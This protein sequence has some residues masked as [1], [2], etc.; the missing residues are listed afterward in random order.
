MR[1]AGSEASLAAE[2]CEQLTASELRQLC[3]SRGFPVAGLSRDDLARGAA[4]RFLEPFGVREVMAALP[5]LWLKALHLVAFSREPLHFLALRA[6]VEPDT[7]GWEVD[8]RGL[9]RQVSAGLLSRGVVL[10][11]E[12]EPPYRE[13]SRYARTHLLLPAAFSALLPPFPIET[14]PFSPGEPVGTLEDLLSEALVSFAQRVESTT[15]QRSDTMADRLSKLLTIKDGILSLSQGGRPTAERMKAIVAD[16]WRSGLASHPSQQRRRANL[17]PGALASHVLEHLPPAAGFTPSA[18]SR[19][20]GE[21]G[22]SV[23]GDEVASFLEDGATAGLL[24]RSRSSGAEPLYRGAP[25]RVPTA[26]LNLIPAKGGL[27]VDPAATDLLPVLQAAAICRVS[28]DRGRL[29]LAPDPIRMGRSLRETPVEVALKL[30]EASPAF[31]A[32]VAEIEKREGKVFVHEGLTVFRV[33]DVGLRALFR[34]R[35]PSAV[36]ELPGGFLACLSGE[37]EPLLAFAKKEGFVA[38]RES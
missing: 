6:L 32:A 33:Q 14:Q 38:R 16:V 3:L 2:T 34:Q 29:L 18:L 27:L 4:A 24:D 37:V 25:E 11:F 7:T 22:L 10:A 5:P 1:A 12:S 20:L 13:K 8:W 15:K 17:E 35:F 21:L 23:K 30:I 31:A 28:I 19:A 9:R 26:R 36:R